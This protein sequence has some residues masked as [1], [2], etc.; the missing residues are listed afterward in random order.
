M[1]YS[2]TSGLLDR[3]PYC[4]LYWYYAV[5]NTHLFKQTASKPSCSVIHGAPL[6]SN[7]ATTRAILQ[8]Q[9]PSSAEAITWQLPQ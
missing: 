1:T 4:C 9:M 7:L 2:C 3:L 5:C 8:Q 6:S